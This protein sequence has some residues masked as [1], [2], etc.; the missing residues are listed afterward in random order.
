MS[1]VIQLLTG[2]GEDWNGKHKTN[3]DTGKTP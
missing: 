3:T 1:V 2:T